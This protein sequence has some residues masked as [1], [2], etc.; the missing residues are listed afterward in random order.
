MSSST[1]APKCL[2]IRSLIYY[3]V[4]KKNWNIGQ[5]TIN[6]CIKKKKNEFIFCFIS[7]S[8][9]SSI[10]FGG[11]G[12]FVEGIKVW[13]ICRKGLRFGGFEEFGRGEFGGGFGGGGGFEWF[14]LGFGRGFGWFRGKF[15]GGFWGFESGFGL[16]FGGAG[17]FVGGFG[18]GE[19]GLGRFGGEGFLEFGRGGR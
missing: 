9:A 8:T 18:L 1:L 14:I 5:L 13:R 19:G 7:V 2:Y 3:S 10:P 17:R 11:G 12:G 4:K 16:G 15:V 6:K